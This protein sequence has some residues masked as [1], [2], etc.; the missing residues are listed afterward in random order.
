VIQTL[1]D[2][3]SIIETIHDRN[4]LESARP[5][6]DALGPRFA[7]VRPLM[8]TAVYLSQEAPL[9]N[10]KMKGSLAQQVRSDPQFAPYIAAG[11]ALGRDPQFVAAYR[12]Y[13]QALKQAYRVP[14]AMAV[15]SRSLQLDGGGE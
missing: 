10:P 6:L 1:N 11:E 14:E 5:K 7:Q 2:A 13:N 12:R 8:T 3:A 15:I 4:T 9:R